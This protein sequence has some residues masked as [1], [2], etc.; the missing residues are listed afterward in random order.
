LPGPPNTFPIPP[1]VSPQIPGDLTIYN[2][3][4]N[5][6]TTPVLS[7]NTSGNSTKDMV[8]TFTPAGSGCVSVYILWGGHLATSEQWGQGAGYLGGAKAHMRTQFLDGDGGKNQ[9]RSIQDIEWHATPTPTR[10]PTPT[11]MPKPTRTWMTLAAGLVWAGAAAGCSTNYVEGR[12]SC[13]PGEEDTC[14]PGWYCHASDRRCYSYPS[15][16]PD[17]HD[18]EAEFDADSGADPGGDGDLEADAGDVEDGAAADVVEEADG[19]VPCSGDSCDDLDPCNGLETCL[20]TGLCRPE[21]GR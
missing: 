11:G 16:R 6:V 4:I 15:E 21:G 14:P 8:V 9:D 18:V 1:D 13:V 10:T 20:M 5:S 12:Y 3:V 19:F 7:G 17:A 2:G